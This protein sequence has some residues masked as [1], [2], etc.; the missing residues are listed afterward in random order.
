[1]RPASDPEIMQ[2]EM[3]SLFIVALVQTNPST[4]ENNK[5]QVTKNLKLP[6]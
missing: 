4:F 2:T 5:K 1:M 6:G 3:G